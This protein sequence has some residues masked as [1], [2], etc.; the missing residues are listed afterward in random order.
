MEELIR[1]AG[2]LVAQAQRTGARVILGIAGPPGAGKSTVAEALVA[3]LG[4]GAA[5]C[6]P[7]DGFH[8]ADE[9]LRASGLRG[10]KGAPETFDADGYASLLERLRRA[11]RP[12]YAPRFD[13]ALEDSIAAAIRIGPSVPLI[14]A[15]GNYLLLWPQVRAQLDEV[16]YLDPPG[17]QRR[18]RLIDRH[19]RHGKAPAEARRWAAEV[20]EANAVLIGALKSGA[21][22]LITRW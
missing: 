9:L 3:G 11:D 22:L 4:P 5:A 17:E 15:E 20:D 21:D 8:I 10:R 1:R 6:A 19:A 7:M 18:Q 13:R 14:V 2:A 16:W 12:V